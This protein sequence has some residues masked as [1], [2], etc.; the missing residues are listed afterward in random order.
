MKKTTGILALVMVVALAAC[1]NDMSFQ[2]T[3]GGMPYKIFPSKEGKQLKVGEFVKVNVI[4]RVN[5]SVTFDSHGKMPLYFPVDSVGTPYDASEIIYKLKVGDSLV[6][7]QLIDTFM[8][9]YPGQVPPQYKKGDRLFTIYTI[10]GVLPEKASMED[11]QKEKSNFLAGEI[12]QVADWLAKNNIKA[13]RTGKGTFVE[14]Q[15]PGTGAAIDSGKYIT[16]NY[17]GSTFSGKVFDSNEIDSFGHNKQP[18]AFTVNVQPMGVRGFEEGVKLFKKG[19]K[20][21][22]FIPSM[23]AYGDRPPQGASIKPYEHLIFEIEVLDV[24]DKQPET[25]KPGMPQNKIDTTQRRK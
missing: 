19:G 12:L 11:Y 18:L 7:V 25:N 23:L 16:L 3:K 13:E 8:K 14:I 2:K 21:R 24:Q 6:A 15:N 1:K 17:T 10:L 9:R 22:L 4:R 5:D 20:G